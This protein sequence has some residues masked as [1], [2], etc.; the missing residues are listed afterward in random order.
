MTTSLSNRYIVKI[1]YLDL[2]LDNIGSSLSDSVYGTL[3]V[4]ANL[5]GDNR[6][7]HNTDV[8]GAVDLQRSVNNTANFLR[9]HRSRA[10]RMEVRTDYEVISIF[11]S[12]AKYNVHIQLFLMNDDH[13]WSLAFAA[14]VEKPGL[15]SASAIS[16]NGS[17]LKR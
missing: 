5:E 14:T 15:V 1:G 10:D 16:A 17:V 3:Q 13:P 8:G 2:T 6:G 12:K 4:S 11:P 7:I 9:H